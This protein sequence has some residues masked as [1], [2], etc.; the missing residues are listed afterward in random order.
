MNETYGLSLGYTAVLDL[1]KS[2][3]ALTSMPSDEGG[4]H[5]FIAMIA[6]N[7]FEIQN[8][9]LEKIPIQAWAALLTQC[10]LACMLRSR[11]FLESARPRNQTVRLTLN[12]CF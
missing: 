10:G 7:S 8:L 2:I 12:R 1:V 9:N 5:I 4:M 6:A 11:C 3:S